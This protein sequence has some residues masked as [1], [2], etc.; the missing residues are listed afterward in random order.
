MVYHLEYLRSRAILDL[1]FIPEEPISVGM[2]NEG[3]IKKVTSYTING[4]RIN[5]I[6]SESIKGS[7]RS[8]ARRLLK[9]M[10]TEFKCDKGKHHDGED[11]NANDIN[12][13]KNKLKG[14]F[15]EEQLNEL[16]NN[17]LREFY[18]ALFECPICRLFGSS[19]LASK[20]VFSDITTDDEV[21]SYTSTAIDRKNRIVREGSL[22]SIEYIKP[23]RLY[24]RIIADNITK[25][26]NKIF[27]T[28][29]EFIHKMGIEIGG[30]KSKGYG[31]LRLDESSRVRVLN[32]I[33]KPISE[34]DKIKN[35]NA[36]LLRENYKELTIG[37]YIVELRSQC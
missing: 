31:L 35:I 21:F 12:E 26:E 34:E 10:N 11:I 30:S 9:S 18:T 25:P 2:Y 7:M 17:Q 16:S 24:L 8:L 3:N 36:L 19:M 13:Y 28:L 6:P 32:L 37:D 27:A 1:Y 15:D 14:I 23:D 20:L 33:P 22:Y 5:F 29:L 4:K